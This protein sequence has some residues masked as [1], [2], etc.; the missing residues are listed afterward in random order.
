MELAANTVYNLWLYHVHFVPSTHLLLQNKHRL[1]TLL[2][3]D[4]PRLRTGLYDIVLASL[5]NQPVHHG[6]ALKLVRVRED[7]YPPPCLCMSP[8]F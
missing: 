4:S 3:P 6:S 5:L 1:Y 2:C 7:S 8:V